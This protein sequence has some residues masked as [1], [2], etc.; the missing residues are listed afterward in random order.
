MHLGQYSS[1]IPECLPEPVPFSKLEFGLPSHALK[2]ELTYEVLVTDREVTDFV[3]RQIR[4]WQN[5]AAS[6]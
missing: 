2:R 3:G 4:P 6:S 5:T 1:F